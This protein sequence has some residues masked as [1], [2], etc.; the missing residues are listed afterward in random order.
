MLLAYGASWVGHAY[1]GRPDHLRHMI[2]LAMEHR[3]FSYL[4]IQSPCVTFDKTERTYSNLTV[5]VTDLPEDHDVHDR[6]AAMKMA[7]SGHPPPLGVYFSELRPTLGDALDGIA[8]KA[9][10]LQPAKARA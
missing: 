7:M 9:G 3:G 4:H 1:A 5:Q 6:A 2:R 10:G 8:E